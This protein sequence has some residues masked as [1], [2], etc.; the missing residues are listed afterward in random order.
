MSTLSVAIGLN[1][2]RIMAPKTPVQRTCEASTNPR[3]TPLRSDAHIHGLR[4]YAH[5]KPRLGA[6][7]HPF[8][9]TDVQVSRKAHATHGMNHANASARQKIYGA[10][11]V[12][13]Q[14]R[15]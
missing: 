6:S 2:G 1:H 3:Q 15:D 7:S 10:L 5:L 13:H 4:K 8:L 12:S 11:N 9:Q 14:F